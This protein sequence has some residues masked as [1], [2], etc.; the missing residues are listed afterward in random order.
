MPHMSEL[1][2]FPPATIQSEAPSTSQSPTQRLM[3]LDALRGFDMFWIIG[4]D[5]LVYALGRIANGGADHAPPDAP[6]SIARLL[7]YE[8]EHAEWYGFHFYDLIFPLFVF[9]VGV[10]I[11]YSLRRV[12]THGRAEA[13]KRVIRRGVLLYV[14]GLLYSGGIADG[15]DNIRWMGVL[16]R[17]AFCYLCTGLIFIFCNVRVMIGISVALL[18]GYWAMMAFVPIRNI[19]LDKA[20]MAALA[21]EKGVSDPHVLFN[22][23]TERVTGKFDHG[24]NVANHFDFQYLPGRKYDTYFDPE[25]YLSNL[26]A[27]VT[28]LFGVFAGLLLVSPHYGDQRKVAYLLGAG[29]AA[30]LLGWAWHFGFGANTLAFPVVKK[31]W[32]SSYVLVAGGYSALLLAAFYTIVDIWKWQAW[33]QPFVWIGMNPITIYLTSNIIGGYRNPAKRFVGGD[34]KAFFDNHIAHGVGDLFV[35][36]VGLFLAFWFARFLYKRKIFLRL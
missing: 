31:I 17:I 33:C 10:S 12:Q 13:V 5:A 14:I 23:T 21:K 11:V 36:I 28:C 16:N 4:A 1:A 6:F 15:W 9:M 24:L 29:V 19:Q 22:Q 35:A 8:L 34:I 32:T 25:G 26:P 2:T 3:S 27:I 20:N 30:V 7:A 18:I